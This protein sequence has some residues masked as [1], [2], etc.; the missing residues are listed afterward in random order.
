MVKLIGIVCIIAG[1]TGVGMSCAQ[2]LELRIAELAQIRQLVILLK[3]EL[4]YMHQPLPEAFLH[5]SEKAASPFREFFVKAAED[6]VERKG[7]SVENIWKQYLPECVSRLHI[8]RQEIKELEKLGNVLGYL[9][10]E[11]QINTLDYYLEQ[12]EWS[13]TQAQEASRSR[14]KLYQYMG[15]LGGAALSILIF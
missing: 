2:D 14:R 12:L 3:G 10:V 15:I 7:R 4:R 5:L 13:S 8:T 1:S 11:M 6:M 9:D